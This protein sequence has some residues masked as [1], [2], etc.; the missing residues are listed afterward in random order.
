MNIP[1]EVPAPTSNVASESQQNNRFFRGIAAAAAGLLGLAT[2]G[3][4]PAPTEPRG[5]PGN[6][7]VVVGGDS[8]TVQANSG[9]LEPVRDRDPEQASETYLVDELVARGYRVSL[10]AEIGA[11]T[12]DLQYVEWPQDLGEGTDIAV[13]AFGTNDGHLDAATGEPKVPMSQF[14]VFDTEHYYPEDSG[15][16]EAPI[17][18]HLRDHLDAVQ[19]RCTA[20]IAP[21][22]YPG[23]GLNETG[24]IIY[25]SYVSLIKTRA[26][27]GL[28]EG[29]VVDWNEF[30]GE[31]PEY[32]D[33][34]GVH[35]A[36]EDGMAPAYLA[37]RRMFTT[38]T[39][40][41][42]GFNNDPTP[43]Q[44]TVITP[45]NIDALEQQYSA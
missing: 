24:Q 27:L 20:L 14:P 16:P 43:G 38:A 36:G 28:G 39:S 35:L 10:S 32:F 17:T 30:A 42:D 44:H 15:D 23:W 4:L 9:P 25:D 8:I 11:K 40:V 1:G 19:P 34:S 5:E 2:T 37:Y 33:A 29:V 31:H 12:A 6:P 7:T 13:F 26:A 3:C 41:C 45:D 18:S 21:Q 22:K